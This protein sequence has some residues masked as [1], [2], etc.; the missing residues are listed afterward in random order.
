MKTNVKPGDLAI[1][2]MARNPENI[3]KIVLVVRQAMRGDRNPLP[4]GEWSKFV[5]ND[6]SQ[7][8]FWYVETQ[9]TDLYIN[10]SPKGVP[11]VTSRC[12]W[13]HFRDACLRPLREGNDDDAVP[14]TEQLTQPIKEL[15]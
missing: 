6:M 14:T 1:V 9:G 12:N 7:G 2:V 13:G 3:G 4:N 10:H 11:R 15:A 8:P 5:P